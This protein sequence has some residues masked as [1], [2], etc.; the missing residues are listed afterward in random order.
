MRYRPT[1]GKYSRYEYYIEISG[2]T[3]R[4]SEKS[5]RNTLIHELIHTV[6]GGLCHTGEWKKWAMF[7]S[8]RTEYDIKRL[9]GDKTSR[10]VERLD[11][12]GRTNWLRP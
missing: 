5:L 9:D 11:N 2:Y 3:L 10:D 1:F 4:N 8:E 6:P 7:V 12:Y